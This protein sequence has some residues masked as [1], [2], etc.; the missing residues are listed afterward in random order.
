MQCFTTGHKWLS[1]MLSLRVMS[2]E[3]RNYIY[4]M[5]ASVAL[6]YTWEIL[7]SVSTR[8]FGEAEADHNFFSSTTATSVYEMFLLKVAETLR[9]SFPPNN[10]SLTRLHSEVPSL[11]KLV[12]ILLESLCVPENNEKDAELH[13][14][15]RVHQVN[16]DHLIDKAHTDGS[17]AKV[18][19]D[20]EMGKPLTESV[21]AIV[22]DS[23]SKAGQASTSDNNSSIS[24]ID[25]Q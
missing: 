20:N 10:K 5:S 25:A 21:S 17:H 23:S 19:K 16:D 1:F 18:S 11:R 12:L 22:K 2:L 15:E 4:M 14:G 13:S 7:G 24:I 3:Q 9:D 8:L 6:S